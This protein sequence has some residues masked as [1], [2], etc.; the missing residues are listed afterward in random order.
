MKNKN[1][2]FVGMIM[3]GLSSQVAAIDLG[4]FNGVELSIGG[5]IKAE[6]IVN[7]PDKG[8]QDFDGSMRQS[9]LNFAA[10]K[11][12]NGHK[13]KGFVEM[14]F[15]DNVTDGKD[16]SYAPR[17]RHAY[18]SIDNVT[19]G[20]TWNGQFLAAAP[21]DVEMVNFWGPGFGTIA[22]NGTVV[23]PDLVVNYAKNGFLVSAQ[24]PTWDQASY[25]DMVAAYT[26]RT[27]AHA[28]NLAVTGREV[29][30]TG[31]DSK[32]GAA[33]SAAAKFKFS[34]TQLAISGFTGKGAG[35]Y[36]G[37]GYSG[38]TGASQNADV[39]A[40][41][42]LITTTGFSTGVTQNFMENLR[43]TVR[44]GQVKAGEVKVGMDK[45]TMEMV[46]VNLIYSYLP[47]LDFGIE[48]RYQNAPT[49][50]DTAAA[51]ARRPKGKQLEMFAMYKF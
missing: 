11:D 8:S 16:S 12:V 20:Q 45:D 38:F 13:L 25:P 30:T 5:Y 51:S 41:G 47:D 10:K 43:G 33:V 9:R 42:D 40:T 24:D 26:Y 31:N 22:G 23:R 49:L 44:Y 37:W 15:W 6:G 39:N 21:L 14:D 7:M 29:N 36:A 3:V 34:S 2:V 18:I 27:G 35:V 28:F 50:P 1:K 4:E 17:L 32:F 19:I 48:W 46:N